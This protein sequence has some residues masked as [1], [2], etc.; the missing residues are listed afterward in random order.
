MEVHPGRALDGVGHGVQTAVAHRGDDL[1]LAV[2]LQRD[3]RG[4]AVHL[5]EV[6]L[7]DRERLIFIEEALLEDAEHF[8]STQLLVA[9]V[10]DILDLVAQVFAHLGGQVVAVVLLQ[11]KADAALAALAVDADDVGVV[12]AADVVRVDGDVGAGPA[13]FA[14]LLAVGHALGDGVLMAAGEGRKDQLARIGGALVDVHPG[15]TLIGGADVRHVG[16]IEFGV[17][18]VAVHVHGQSDGIDVAG[19][20]AVAEQAALH[21]LCTSQHGQLGTGY[22]GAAVVVGV[23]GDDDAVAVLEVPVT[24]FDLVC[25]DVRHAHL[26]GDRKVDDHRAVGRRLHDVQHGV[27]DLDGIIDLGAGEALRAVLEQEVAL[28]LLTELLDQPG[29]VGG[30]LLD[31]F[32]A[33]M[34]H[35]LTLGRGGGVVEVDDRAGRAL[36]GLEGAADDVVAA[37]GQHLHG[38]IVGD[39]ILL[40]EGAQELVL[41]LAGGREADLDLLEADPDQHLEE[42]QLLFQAHGHDQCLVAVAQVHAAPCRCLFNVIFFDPAVVTGRYGVIPRCVLGSVHHIRYPPGFL[43]A[44]IQHFLQAALSLSVIASQ[45]HLPRSGRFEAPPFG[46]AGAKR[47]RG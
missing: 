42:L 35:L 33:L 26:N 10:G 15:H 40:N 23:G 16:E 11:H 44:Y 24:V 45:C 47:L 6:C 46:G 22:A 18:A 1:A 28:V 37:L 27:A 21:A 30:D 9:V 12:G 25:V 13:V 8:G 14:V 32:L 2:P 31:L 34:E 4:D 38:D 19:A 36:D 20:L 17:H 43:S 39:H 29:T 7:D 3:G 5:S 41:G